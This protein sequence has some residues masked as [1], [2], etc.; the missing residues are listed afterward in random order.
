M[1]LITLLDPTQAKSNLLLRWKK[2]LNRKKVYPVLIF[3]EASIHLERLHTLAKIS[4]KQ[5]ISTSSPVF[6][7]TDSVL[8]SADFLLSDR[9][10]KGEKILPVFVDFGSSSK[11]KKG[12]GFE[13]QVELLKEKIGDRFSALCF[14]ETGKAQSNLERSGNRNWLF[15]KSSLVVEIGG[16]NFKVLRKDLPQAEEGDSPLETWIPGGLLEDRS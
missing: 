16:N 4:S 1:L 5:K 13:E 14:L 8:K 9:I 7:H 6:F 15:H 2:K 11:D 10:P 3:P 12:R